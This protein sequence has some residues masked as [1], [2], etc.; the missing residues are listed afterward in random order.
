ME[1]QYKII[2][3]LWK[4]MKTH[5]PATGT[6]NWAKSVYEDAKTFADAHG[7]TKFAQELAQAAMWELDR[8]AKG[9]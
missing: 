8:L 5:L 3:D 2:C 9:E 6:D 4:Y 7:N 1:E